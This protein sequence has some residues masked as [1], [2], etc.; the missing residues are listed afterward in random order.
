MSAVK[1]HRPQIIGMSAL[2][3]TT[4]PHMGETIQALKDEGLRE[5]VKV[6]VGGAPVTGS[7]ANEIGADG[8]SEDAMGAVELAKRLVGAVDAATEGAAR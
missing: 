3:T 6:M 4:L 1:E 8:Y 2:L 7:W 5:S